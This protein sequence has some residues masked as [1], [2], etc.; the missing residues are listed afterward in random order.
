MKIYH[1]IRVVSFPF[2]YGVV[3]GLTR[4]LT[5]T[6]FHTI[7][8]LLM[9]GEER[10]MIRY[11]KSLGKTDLV[12]S[13]IGVFTGSHAVS[14]L[15]TLPIKTLYLVDPYL[16]Y[17][18]RGELINPVTAKKI[19]IHNLAPFKEKAVWLNASEL[20]SNLDFIYVDGS[21]DYTGVKNDL[22]K[23]YGLVKEGGVFGGHDFVNWY[24]GVI[25]AVC[26]FT[27]ANNIELFVEQPDWWVIKARVRR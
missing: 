9:Y 2:R 24:P 11:L 8:H 13:E 1:A 12:G 4:V 26:E 16:P 22:E 27:A 5:P 14:I 17:M 19:A 20:P 25:K 15:N 23:Y 7:L 18:E 10:P 3:L 21:H 6:L